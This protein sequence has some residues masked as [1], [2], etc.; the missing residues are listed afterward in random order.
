MDKYD[1]RKFND[2]DIE[3]MIYERI[4][5]ADLSGYNDT[6]KK[7][8]YLYYLMN[9]GYSY[10]EKIIKNEDVSDE[11]YAHISEN[12]DTLKVT[13]SMAEWVVSLRIATSGSP[14]FY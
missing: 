13:A 6:D 4:N 12:I 3:N 1:E 9:K 7:A 11:E 14:F 2:D 5:D 8:A 10:A